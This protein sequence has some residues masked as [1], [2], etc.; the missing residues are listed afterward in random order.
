MPSITGLATYS[1]LT[2]VENKTTDVSSL[3]KKKK[4]L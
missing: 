1:A 4:R 2:T 3:V